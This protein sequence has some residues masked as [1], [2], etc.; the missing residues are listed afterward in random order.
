MEPLYRL[1]LCCLGDGSAQTLCSTVKLQVS[2][3]REAIVIGSSAQL[4]ENGRDVC[5]GPLGA[6][7]C[8]LPA[9]GDCGHSRPISHRGAGGAE[10]TH[11]AIR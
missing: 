5:Q 4:D 3:E 10:A 1:D 8:V 7:P 9:D 11:H 2:S 6:N